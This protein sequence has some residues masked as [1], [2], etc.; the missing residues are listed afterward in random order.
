MKFQISILK[1]LVVITILLGMSFIHA[2]TYRIDVV[3]GNGQASAFPNAQPQ[4]FVAQATDTT[5][6]LPVPNVSVT[7]AITGYSG[8]A[9]PNN[10]LSSF[11]GVATPLIG[12][13]YT[14]TTDA[15]GQA[16]VLF[17]PGFSNAGIGIGVCPGLPPIF[18]TNPPCTGF[19]LSAPA[20][21]PDPTNSAIAVVSGDQQTVT[22]GSALAQ[23]LVARMTAITGGAAVAGA[24]V[25]W[26]TYDTVTGTA[27]LTNITTTVTDATGTTS[28][29]FTPPNA[30]AGRVVLAAFPSTQQG[31]QFN[32]NVNPAPVLSCA[33]IVSPSPATVGQAFTING[34][35]TI[36]GVAA[37]TGTETWTFPAA[38]GVTPATQT[39]VLPAA[40][41]TPTIATA[42]TYP[43]ALTFSS[44]GS[45]IVVNGFSVTVAPP[46]AVAC[47][48]TVSPT[49]FVTGQAFTINGNC[50]IN[51]VAATAGTEGW[52][53]PAIGV[54]AAT[55]LSRVLPAAAIQQTVNTPG[56]YSF[57][58]QFNSPSGNSPIYALPITVSQNP[59]TAA[60]DPKAAS[61]IKNIVSVL[62]G[63]SIISVRTQF[64]N[65]QRRFQY[66]RGGG[67]VGFSTDINVNASVDGQQI[68]MPSGKSAE[69]AESS[70]E[71]AAGIKQGKWGAYIMGGVDML[72][73]KGDSGFK[74]GTNGITAGADYRVSRRLLV[75]GAL[76][77]M[78]S[79]TE[80]ANGAG[81]QTARGTSI[82][83][84][85]SFEPAPAWF[86]DLGLSSGR[87]SFDIKRAQ[88]D[89]GIAKASTSGNSTGLTFTGGYSLRSNGLLL[90]PYGRVDTLKVTVDGFTEEGSSALIVG[91]Q[92]LRST[93]LS[94]GGIAQYSVNTSFGIVVPQARLEFQRQS[95]NSA[96]GVNA[97]LVGSDVQVLVTPDLEIDKTSGTFGLGLSTQFR[98]GLSAF[99]D[100]EQLFGKSNTS[101]YRL[102][103]GLKLEF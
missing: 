97:R 52:T 60:P 20:F 14:Q 69:A 56:S 16:S 1:C 38:S 93:V 84:Y 91:A 39:R 59:K 22:L 64:A 70:D 79:S 89:G 48:P 71:T 65:I 35:C 73:V 63:I 83:L 76:G 21:L 2:Q 99:A 17:T 18:Y 28:I 25:Q 44:G 45:T 77:F 46:P 85:S 47:A 7:W 12:G 75:G 33:P 90:T 42:G 26:L 6:G 4:P 11:N 74:I 68:P 81:D 24:T 43:I 23:P 86:L 29:P 62:G 36:N 101:Q 82:T 31:A 102:T 40:A 88:S 78:R 13:T 49:A 98:R 58:L 34:N 32:V 55:N 51:G 94:A 61:D 57:T 92:N 27:G 3:S 66:I 37:T 87:N 100:Y 67:G 10:T 19:G 72:K 50:T 15:N 54:L 95:Q 30:N 41:L 8:T 103:A 9:V 53:I 5:T 96:Q 80:I